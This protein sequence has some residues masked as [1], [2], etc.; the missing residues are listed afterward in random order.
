MKYLTTN[1]ITIHHINNN[2]KTLARGV[3]NRIQ[4]IPLVTYTFNQ[5]SFGVVHATTTFS[6]LEIS[7]SFVN[8][9]KDVRCGKTG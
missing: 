2:V 6:K 1:L 3:Q 4:N 5:V 9:L 7:Y 8:S